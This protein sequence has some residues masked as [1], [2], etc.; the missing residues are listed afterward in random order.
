MTSLLVPPNKALGCLPRRSLLGEVCPI[1]GERIDV[2]PKEEWAGLIPQ[3]QLRPFVW[4]VFDQDGVGSCATE[5]TSQSVM[6]CREFVGANRVLLNPW[7]IYHTT[8]G[9]YDGGSTIDGNLQFARQN[10]VCP[11]SVWPR[12]E[13]GEDGYPIYKNGYPVV[14]NSW[15]DTPPPEAYEAA[16]RLRIDEFYDISTLLEV[17]SALLKDFVVV[18]GWKGHSVLAVDLI[19]EDTLLYINSWQ[20][21]W[22][23]EGFGVL[24]LWEVNWGYGAF[25]VRSTIR[26]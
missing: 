19:D 23:D 18:F 20:P 2:I 22:G 10:G 14:I 17:G 6:V 24:K 21:S 1:F 16:R 9:G 25:A 13:R 7:F 15:R 3:H 4:H 11:E 12:Y 26:G 8:S 5:S